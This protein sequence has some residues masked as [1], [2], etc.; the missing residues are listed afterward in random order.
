L[1]TFSDEAGATTTKYVLIV[2]FFLVAA[3]ITLVT[4]S[5]NF[6]NTTLEVALS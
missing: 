1:S 5:V 4:L 6:S 2:G 3:I